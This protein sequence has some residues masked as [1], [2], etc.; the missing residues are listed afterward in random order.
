MTTDLSKVYANLDP[1]QLALLAYNHLA[2]SDK[3]EREKVL[4]AVPQRAYLTNDIEFTKMHM[5]LMRIMA[6]LPLFYWRAKADFYQRLYGGIDEVQALVK[7]NAITLA[8]QHVLNGLG[9]VDDVIK[10]H[11]MGDAILEPI[12]DDLVDW[13]LYDQYSALFA[14]QGYTANQ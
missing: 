4:A 7:Y 12:S 11:F 8:I 2:D 5:D 13:Q 1:A 9:I 6:G 10:V 3:L 14:Q